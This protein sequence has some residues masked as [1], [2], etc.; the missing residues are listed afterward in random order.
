MSEKVTAK[1][2]DEFLKRLRE[3]H[4]KKL[5][6]EKNQ[7]EQRPYNTTI[8]KSEIDFDNSR[9]RSKKVIVKNKSKFFRKAK[10]IAYKVFIALSLGTGAAFSGNMGI[11]YAVNKAQ[12]NKVN[13]ALDYYG[14]SEE[15]L[16]KGIFGPYLKFKTL[17]T[18]HIKIG[19]DSSVSSS[20]A[21]QFNYCFDYIN[22]IFK[23]INPNYHFDIINVN[24]K[25]ECNIYVRVADFNEEFSEFSKNTVAA[26]T[27]RN[28]LT[29]ISYYSMGSAEIIYNEAYTND[30]ICERFTM[31]HEMMHAILENHDLT[32]N[33][34]EL[35]NHHSAPY[36][37]LSYEHSTNMMKNLKYFNKYDDEKK[38][39]EILDKFITFTPFDIAAFAARYGNF[40]DEA[41]RKACTQLIVD[42]YKACYEIFGNKKYFL[43]SNELNIEGYPKRF[44]QFVIKSNTSNKYDDVKTYVF[45]IDKDDDFSL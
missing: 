31:C 44:E 16:G 14:G 18:K 25:D 26:T 4:Q 27:G 41:N 20:T 6:E 22:D 5:Q 7:T 21:Q 10:E 11:Q 45:T 29:F 34:N 13:I 17:D 40:K 42:T 38:N 36:S 8:D 2:R 28:P 35:I 9:T 24:S 30:P 15:Y 32:Y 23:V 33:E 39:Q 37:V 19:I 1:Q 3:Y 43:S 12:S